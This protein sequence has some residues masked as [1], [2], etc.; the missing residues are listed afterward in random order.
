[1]RKVFV[2]F[3]IF[4]MSSVFAQTW[5]DYILEVRGDTVVVKD[6]VDM[7]QTA[8]TLHQAIELDPSPTAGRVYELRVNGYY[9][10]ASNPTTPADRAVTIAGADYTRMVVNDSPDLPPIVCGFWLNS[11]GINFANDLTIRNAIVKS[12]NRI[13]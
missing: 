2:L 13:R 12:V 7:G 8:S 9:P 3:G 1:M 11:G 10:L 4:L 5:D 6:Y